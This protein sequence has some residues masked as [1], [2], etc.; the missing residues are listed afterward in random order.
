MWA[1]LLVGAFAVMLQSITGLDRQPHTQGH[2]VRIATLRNQLLAIPGRLTT[3]AR[4]P[5]L[6]LQPGHRLLP[7]VLG[8][9]RALPA[10]T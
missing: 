8:R 2:R 6:R 1:G 10:P 5:V 3:H 7:T 9:L 4:T